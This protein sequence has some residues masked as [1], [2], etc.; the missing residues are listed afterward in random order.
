MGE[1]GR[2]RVRRDFDLNRQA[3]AFAELLRGVS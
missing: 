3:D 1:A 2:R